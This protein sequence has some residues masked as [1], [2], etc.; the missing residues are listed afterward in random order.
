[1]EPAPTPGFST[2]GPSRGSGE[3]LLHHIKGKTDQAKA[4]AKDVGES[5][6]DG[7]GRIGDAARR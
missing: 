1:L 3:A 6:K 7:A 2:G 4:A 5:V